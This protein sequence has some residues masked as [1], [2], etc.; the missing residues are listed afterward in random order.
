MAL[1]LQEAVA[2]V[3]VVAILGLVVTVVLVVVVQAAQTHLL[4]VLAE[5]QTQ[6]V[7]VAVHITKALR[8][9]QVMAVQELLFLD[10]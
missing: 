3:V 4:T 8:I 6:V 10:I 1:L 5:L 7:A 2:V 9:K